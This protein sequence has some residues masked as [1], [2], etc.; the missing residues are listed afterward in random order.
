MSKYLSIKEA[1][2]KFEELPLE[3]IDEPIIITQE[4]KPVMTAIS[5]EQFESM[6]ETLSILADQT[7]AHKLQ[8]SILQAERGETISWEEAKAQLGI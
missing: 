3:L 8:E 2:N 7:F 6:I 1:K 5:Y 4:G